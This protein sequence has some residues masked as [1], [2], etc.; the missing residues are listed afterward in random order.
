MAQHRIYPIAFKRQ[1][2]QEFLSGEVSLHGLA[3]DRR[4][5]LEKVH[6]QAHQPGRSCPRVERDRL[7]RRGPPAAAI[8]PRGRWPA[9]RGPSAVPPPAEGR[10]GCTARLA[11]S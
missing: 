7:E 11:G 9:R 10:A 3:Y 5:D 2:V 8:G 1:V 4:V 6:N